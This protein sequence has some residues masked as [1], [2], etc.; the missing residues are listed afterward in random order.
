[1]ST[2]RRADLVGSQK[3]IP[4]PPPPPFNWTKERNQQVGQQT[5]QNKTK[6]TSIELKKETSKWDNKQNKTN[7]KKNQQNNTAEIRLASQKLCASGES[8]GCSLYISGRQML[9]A[10]NAC[11]VLSQM[12]R[13]SSW[14]MHLNGLEFTHEQNSDDKNKN[15]GT[16]PFGSKN[17]WTVSVLLCNILL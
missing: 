14:R 3:S 11:N 7:K 6:K 2:L 12:C 8:R 15:S 9:K 4:P 5:K 13:Y 10:Q 16:H 17:N 1:M